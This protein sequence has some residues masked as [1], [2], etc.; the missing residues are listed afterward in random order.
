MP[1]E[2]TFLGARPDV[3]IGDPSNAEST[4]LLFPFL[5]RP[6]SARGG[7]WRTWR[8][9][10]SRRRPC[11]RWCAVSALV[12]HLVAASDEVPTRADAFQGA[13]ILVRDGVNARVQHEDVYASSGLW[14]AR[15]RRATPS[16]PRRK[17]ETT[18]SPPRRRITTQQPPRRRNTTRQ[19][20]PRRP[21]ND[22]AVSRLRTRARDA[23]AFFG[24]DGRR[25]RGASREKRR[26]DGGGGES[27]RENRARNTR[28]VSFG[29]CAG[30]EAARDAAKRVAA[31]H[32]EAE[33]A[34]V[35]ARRRRWRSRRPTRNSRRFGRRNRRSERT[36]IF[37]PPRRR[38]TPVARA[39]EET[40]AALAEADRAIAFGIE[41]GGRRT[42]TRPSRRSASV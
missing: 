23:I 21:R 40:V 8:R 7:A 31:L 19:S 33:E 39:R 1:M 16:P 26:G 14:L 27:S 37:E 15:K 34:N 2:T 24:A 32:A 3:A 35:D 4:S 13:E 36:R 12:V 5:R 18:P 42:P 28:I 20:P 41:K 29:R 25:G 22:D 17:S 11:R 38:R 6:G 10:S 30:C 9:R